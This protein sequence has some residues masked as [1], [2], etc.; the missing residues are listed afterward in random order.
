VK[1]WTSLAVLCLEIWHDQMQTSQDVPKITFIKGTVTPVAAEHRA[2]T[3]SHARSSGVEYE[4]ILYL[5]LAWKQYRRGSETRLG[6]ST[7][8]VLTKKCFMDSL[9]HC[10]FCEA[11]LKKSITIEV[12]LVPLGGR[13]S[14]S[15]TPLIDGGRRSIFL[16]LGVCW[17]RGCQP[18]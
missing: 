7:G 5:R 16:A 10:S 1:T 18:C 15:K 13:R 11:A 17:A 6:A 14:S 3:T 12:A 9:Y 8:M 4:K 2:A